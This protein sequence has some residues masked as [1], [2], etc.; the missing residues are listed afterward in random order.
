MGASSQVKHHFLE[1]PSWRTLVPSFRAINQLLQC[2][3]LAL[4]LRLHG[5]NWAIRRHIQARQDGGKAVD[6]IIVMYTPTPDAI[7]PSPLRAAAEP[8]CSSRWLQTRRLAVQWPCFALLSAATSA[9]VLAV[10]W[11]WPCS[12]QTY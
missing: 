6:I 11:P 4:R 7:P 1:V 8:G 5:G 10:P 2:S 9:A 12:R 3:H